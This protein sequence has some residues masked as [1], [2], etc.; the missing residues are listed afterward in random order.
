M[1][2]WKALILGV[3]EGITEYLPVSSTG[4]L[5]VAQRSIGIAETDA[6]DAFA[7]VI[8]AGAILAVLSLYRQRCT[9]MAQG[10]L[11]RN[12]TGLHLAIC[13]L[14]AFLP[15]A[16]L[17]F[18]F[19]DVIERWLFGPLPVAIAWAVGGIVLLVLPSRP[20]RS[21]AYE[22]SALSIRAALVIGLA[23]CIALWPG[24]S[25]SLTTILGGLAVGLSL[26]AAVEFSFLLG[27]LTLGVAT[28]YKGLQSG[29]IMVEAYGVLPLCI[30]F[31]AAWVSA[32][33]AV[34]WMVSWLNSR[35]LRV[36]AWWRLAAAA[37]VGIA[38]WQGWYDFS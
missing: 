30:G 14:V 20:V 27:L 3:V 17:G 10:L 9:Q 13:L 8:Q 4:H 36:F 28:V 34:R 23:Q 25:R 15:A 16:L 22:L 24:T 11:G 2:W 12:Q 21:Q 26:P 38:L 19:H 32:I 7:I 5:I 6:S 31:V 37:W 33:V 18:V 29:S 1:E 35:G